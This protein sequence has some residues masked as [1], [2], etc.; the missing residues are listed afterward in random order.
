MDEGDL[1]VAANLEEQ[2][3]VAAAVLEA[4]V[5]DEVVEEDKA[6]VEGEEQKLQ[7]TYRQC[8]TTG[9]KGS[10]ALV[11]TYTIRLQAPLYHFQMVPLHLIC[12]VGSSLMKCGTY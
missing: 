1:E 8:L 12:S 4:V 10:L 9:T 5:E 2:P 3:E 7:L 6:V 11:L